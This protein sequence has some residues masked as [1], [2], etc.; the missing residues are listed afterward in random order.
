MIHQTIRLYRNSFKGISKEV[1]LLAT[2]MLINRSGTMVVPFLTIYLTHELHFTLQ[3]AGIVSACFGIGSIVGTFLGGQLTDR[4]GYYYVQFWSLLLAGLVYLG[5]E[6]IHTFPLWCVS[7]FMLTTI[8]DA[9][10]PANMASVAVFST[11]ETRTRSVSLI[12][13]AINTG[14]TIGPA[15]GGIVAAYFGYR[16]LFYIDG[17]TCIAAAIFFS[18]ALPK[19]VLQKRL[20]EEKPELELPAQPVYRDYPFLAFVA[21]TALS[22]IAFFQMMSTLPLFFKQELRLNEDHI[23]V[24][25]AM[26]GI[27]VALFEMPIVYLLEH[28]VKLLH[29]IMIGAAMFGLSFLVLNFSPWLGAAIA[30]ILLLTL[31]EILAMP[32]ANA[33]ALARSSAHNRGRYMA[34]YGIAYSIALIFAPYLGTQIAGKWGFGTLWY[35]MVGFGFMSAAGYYFLHKTPAQRAV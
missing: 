18:V 35:V 32:F 11:P 21:F 3:Q 29:T 14:W 13:L 19:K 16:W 24:L 5:L 22:A 20:A 30:C 2:V 17:L 8:A 26:N 34:L 31:G 12:R 33:Y 23:G 9:L 25:L 10:R 27:L 1:W 6:H 7:I 28:R 4:F 15:L